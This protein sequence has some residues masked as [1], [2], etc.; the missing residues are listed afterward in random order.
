MGVAAPARLAGWTPIAV[1]GDGPPIVRWCFTEGVQFDEPFFEQTIDRC[2]LDPFRLLFWRETGI[3]PLA[4]LAVDAPGLEPA[5][6]IFHMSRCGSTLVSRMLASLT[7]VL[8]VSEAA[9]IDAVLRAAEVQWLRWMVSALGQPRRSG[10]TR[11][12]VKLDAW[13]IFALPLVREAF[14]GVPCVFVYREPVEVVMSHLSR[15]GYH[16]V[17]GTMS[18]EGLGLPE[19]MSESLTPEEYIAAVLGSICN[20]AVAGVRGG[21]L[22]LLKYD[23][24]PAAVEARVAPLFGIEV[25][26]AARVAFARAAGKDA[27]NPYLPF[28]PDA[29]DKQRRASARTREAV[30]I[31]LR[32]AY[33]ELEGLRC[34]RP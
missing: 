8:V 23:S 5:G 1:R 18:P 34:S 32:P 16:T 13:A 30:D 6:F 2:L 27:K 20:A 3:D 25:G 28:V 19:G 12:V 33:E 11:L 26:P 7:N 17:P 4:E 15:R 21:A 31:W 10:Q 14:P 22:T 29:G 24:L 9:P